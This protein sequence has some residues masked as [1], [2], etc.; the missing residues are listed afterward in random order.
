MNALNLYVMLSI[1]EK[2]GKEN[3]IQTTQTMD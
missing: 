2:T 3:V 1:A